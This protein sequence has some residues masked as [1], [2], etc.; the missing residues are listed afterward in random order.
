M[1]KMGI[2]QLAKDVLKRVPGSYLLAPYYRRA[3]RFSIGAAVGRSK[4]VLWEGAAS[5]APNEIA[6]LWAQLGAARAAE[7]RAL[8]R[9]DRLNCAQE[10]ARS[11]SERQ[12][13]EVNRLVDELAEARAS[14]YAL[15]NMN[16]TQG[17][18]ITGKLSLLE[19]QM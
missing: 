6:R 5:V 19:Y 8:I 14:A 12:R 11:E 17:A 18:L 3:R 1:T 10:N 2:R 16:A 9:L 15:K 7:Q 4:E 13:S